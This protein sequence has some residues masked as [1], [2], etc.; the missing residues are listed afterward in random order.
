MEKVAFRV[1]NPQYISET[2]E[3][4][5]KVTIHC[6]YKDIHEVSIGAKIYSR[7]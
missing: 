5:A 1:Q 7:E 6:L 3:D 2:A 4:R